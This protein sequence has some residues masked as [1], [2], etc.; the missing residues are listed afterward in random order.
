MRQKYPNNISKKQLLSDLEFNINNLINILI[1][2]EREV[3]ETE[4]R[5]AFDSVSAITWRWK[6]LTA[7][8]KKIMCLRNIEQQLEFL[9]KQTKIL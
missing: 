9:K 8:H 5:V 1:N 2:S 7:D 6:S 3:K 4:I